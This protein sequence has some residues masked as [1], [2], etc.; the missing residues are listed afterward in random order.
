MI[1]LDGLIYYKLD[2]ESNGYGNDETKNSGLLG[3]EIDGNFN[4]LRGQDI[5]K[6]YFDDTGTLYITKYNGDILKANQ[7]DEP[8]YNFEYDSKTG[9]LH[10][11]KPNQEV[12]ELEGFHSDYNFE[13]DSETGTLHIVKP[14]QDVIKLEGFQSKSN[15]E[16]YHDSSLNGK[17]N[18]L[19][20]L[21][22]SNLLKTSFYRPVK[23]IINCIDKNETLPS[24]KNLY[25][26]YITKEKYYYFGKLY[27]LKG[28]NEISNRLKEINSEW[29]IPTKD[30]WDTILNAIDCANP[31][32]NST[33]L[34]VELGEF[35]GAALKSFDFWYSTEN[36]EVLSDDS[37]DFSVYPVGVCYNGK[38]YF[39]GLGKISS[40]WTSTNCTCNSDKIIKTF[41]FDSEKVTQSK[42][43]NE[44]YFSLR[45]VKKLNGDNFH[46]T[47]EL[48]GITY[49][50]I[51]IPNTDLIWTKENVSFSVSES[52]FLIPKEWDDVEMYP[53][54]IKYKFYIN[55]WNGKIWEKQELKNGE[56][57]IVLENENGEN[58]QWTLINNDLID[59]I[60]FLKREIGCFANENEQIKIDENGIYFDGDFGIF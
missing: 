23:K 33:E 35:A 53:E 48:D 16:I 42:T 31:N 59:Y 44:N 55:E 19:S 20:P 60:N 39:S 37:Y 13:Y 8:D 26:R 40:F 56:S 29:H 18:K 46:L 4:F 5:E 43:G 30:E 14:N 17:G 41:E 3:E 47:E 57:V 21:S 10:I 15:S 49:N 12:I 22:I 45:L 36:N 51:H 9:T 54:F 52:E 25:D 38:N 34:D 1:K 32:H 50:C 27:S 28:V 6:I 7:Y 58:H 24:E 2:S 11:V